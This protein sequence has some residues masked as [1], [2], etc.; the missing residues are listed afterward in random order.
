MLNVFVTKMVPFWVPRG[1][2]GHHCGFILGVWGTPGDTKGTHRRLYG[3]PG[4]PTGALQ[5]LLGTSWG[6]LGGPGGVPGGFLDLVWHRLGSIFDQK[7]CQKVLP[8]L[9]WT[10]DVFNSLF[11]DVCSPFGPKKRAK[12]MEGIQN[13]GFR[14]FQHWLNFRADFDPKMETFLRQNGEQIAQKSG[15]DQ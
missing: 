8:Q 6:S 1:R 13:S 14:P 4:R 9:P 10:C 11:C 3:P 12:V 2:L 5:G 7:W 15:A